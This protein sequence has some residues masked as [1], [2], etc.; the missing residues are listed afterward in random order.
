MTFII[1]C[2]AALLVVGIP[3]MF[4]YLQKDKTQFA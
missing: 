1:V 2:C 3:V 4:F